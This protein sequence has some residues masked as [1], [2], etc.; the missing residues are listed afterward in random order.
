[1][2]FSTNF[3]NIE[4]YLLLQYIIKQDTHIYNSEGLIIFNVVDYYS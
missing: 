4:Q 1:M 3:I 2:I